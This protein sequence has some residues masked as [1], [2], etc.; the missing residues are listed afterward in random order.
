MSTL[1]PSFL[2][3]GTIQTWMR[4]NFGQIPHL[5]V[6]LATLERLQKDEFEFPSDPT[7]D[8]GVSCP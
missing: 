6:E 3:G 5:T 1:A 4:S 8:Y 2:I 7:T